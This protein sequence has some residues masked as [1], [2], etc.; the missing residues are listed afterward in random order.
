MVSASN[1]HGARSGRLRLALGGQ[2]IAE[3]SVVTSTLLVA[4]VA[5]SAEFMR[6]HG[7]ETPF[8]RALK[9][10]EI[11]SPNSVKELREKVAPTRRFALEATYPQSKRR[12]L[13]QGRR[14][15]LDLHDRS[16]R[17]VRLVRA[18][19]DG[20][21]R[22]D[23]ILAHGTRGRLDACLAQTRTAR[24]GILNRSRASDVQILFQRASRAWSKRPA[25][26]RAPPPIELPS[27]SRRLR[28]LAGLKCD[29]GTAVG[30]SRPPGRLD[31]KRPR[32]LSPSTTTR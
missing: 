24:I 22:R 3:A 29:S 30:L 7:T 4:D 31:A 15:M 14:S 2:A 10:I 9:R 28:E 26:R 1:I 25:G 11:A 8:A 13:R 17:L 6:A 12:I 32:R 27:D 18:I 20:R 21:N 19:G 23:A 16:R 5:G